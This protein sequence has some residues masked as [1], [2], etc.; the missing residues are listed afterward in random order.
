MLKFTNFDDASFFGAKLLSEKKNRTVLISKICENENSVSEV[1][2]LA[3]EELDIMEIIAHGEKKLSTGSKVME[4]ERF[5]PMKLP[6][7]SND[8]P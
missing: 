3:N 6:P 2:C 5:L 8:I 4:V 7:I 1:F